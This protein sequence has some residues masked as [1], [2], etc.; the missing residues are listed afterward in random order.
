ME[1]GSWRLFLSECISPSSRSNILH[2]IASL[3]YLWT[4]FVW[5]LCRTMSLSHLVLLLTIFVYPCLSRYVTIQSHICSW[6]HSLTGWFLGRRQF[7]PGQQTGMK[8]ECIWSGQ[9]SF[10]AQCAISFERS[11][12]ISSTKIQFW[13]WVRQCNHVALF[14]PN[15]SR[16]CE[17]SWPS[18]SQS[19]HF[20]AKIICFYFNS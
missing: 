13:Q 17:V 12:T 7:L 11:G 15:F 2:L 9:G 19:A 1:E 16:L 18:V 8:W 14:L 3:S 5:V 6:W 10:S 4:W 20:L